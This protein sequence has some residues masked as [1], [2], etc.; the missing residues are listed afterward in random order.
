MVLKV[1]KFTKKDT[2]AEKQETKGKSKCILQA[3]LLYIVN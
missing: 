2:L 1:D 3:I